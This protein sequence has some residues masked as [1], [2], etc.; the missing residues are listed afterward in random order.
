[1]QVQISLLSTSAYLL[2]ILFLNSVMV[3]RSEPVKIPR[4]ILVVY[5]VYQLLINAYI[6]FMIQRHSSSNVWGLGLQ[7]TL[8]LRY[9]IYLHCMTKYV[10]FIDTILIVLRKKSNQLSFLHLY[11]HSTV[12]VIWA[13]VY[14]TWPMYHSAA[15]IYG[16]WINSWVHVVMYF[17]YMTTAFAVRLPLFK[18]SVTVIQLTQFVTCMIHAI[19]TVLLDSVPIYYSGVQLC[20]HISLFYLFW[21]LLKPTPRINGKML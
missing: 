2:S 5:N 10:D 18:K 16:A 20:Y 13:W 6:G 15:Y 12:G 3:S 9:C 4:S 1:M 8:N 19:C 7:D 21:P 14:E 11:H 17:Y